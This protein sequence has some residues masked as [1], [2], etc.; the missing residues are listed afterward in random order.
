VKR[1]C[2]ERVAETLNR[3]IAKSARLR[4]KA[5]IGTGV[6]TNGQAVFG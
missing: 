4:F 5:P 3:G 1:R 6:N 2:L